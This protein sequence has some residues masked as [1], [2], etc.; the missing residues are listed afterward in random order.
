M[1]IYVKNEINSLSDPSHEDQL[2]KPGTTIKNIEDDLLQPDTVK[3]KTLAG[4]QPEILQLMEQLRKKKG[5]VS[6]YNSIPK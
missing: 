2:S 3:K 1:K 5:D 4:W 6:V